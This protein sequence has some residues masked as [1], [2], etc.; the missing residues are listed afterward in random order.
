[1]ITVSYITMTIL[2]DVSLMCD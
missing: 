1:M 2:N